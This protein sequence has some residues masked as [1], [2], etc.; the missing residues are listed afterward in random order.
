M[1][2]KEK[3]LEKMKNVYDPEI[4]VNV[5]DL[6]LVYDVKIE[7]GGKVNILMTLTAPGCPI[8]SYIAE[9]VKRELKTLEGVKEVNVEFTFDPPWSPERVTE[10]GKEALRS[11]GFDI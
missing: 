5:V 11:M 3:I 9:Q 2:S 1:L 4:P 10:E 8:Y 7:E 6:G